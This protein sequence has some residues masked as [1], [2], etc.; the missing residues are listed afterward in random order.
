MKRKQ[1]LAGPPLAPVSEKGWRV[2]RTFIGSKAPK[3]IPPKHMWS[4]LMTHS[5]GRP[6]GWHTLALMFS[7]KIAKRHNPNT[8]YVIYCTNSYRADRESLLDEKKKG[9]KFIEENSRCW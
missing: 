9:K 4:Y 8:W 2:W 7:A 6:F 5:D 1:V 3:K